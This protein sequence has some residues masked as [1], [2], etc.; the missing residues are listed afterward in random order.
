MKRLILTI[1][2][3]L[4]FILSG[5]LI[6]EYSEKFYVENLIA[7]KNIW[8]YL[9][10]YKVF[11][12]YFFELYDTDKKIDKF[13]VIFKSIQSSICSMVIVVFTTFYL[14]NFA[15]PRSFIIITAFIDIMYL[16]I[17]RMLLNSINKH[18]NIC[19][20]CNDKKTFE[21]IKN[22]LLF[23]NEEISVEHVNKD[24]SKVK[25]IIKNCNCD[26]LIFSSE[27]FKDFDFIIRLSWYAYKN[28]VNMSLFPD[29]S[30]SFIS[31]VDMSDIN[32]VPLINLGK[33]RLNIWQNTVK[34]TVDILISLVVFIFLIP[35]L[36]F[37]A[38]IIKYDSKGP[39]F[40]SQ[41]RI[42]YKGEKFK[43]IKFRT[44]ID[45]AEKN[46]GPKFADKDDSR[47]TS[48]GRFL[49]KYRIDELPQFFNVFMGNMSVVGP[50]PEREI[51]IKKYFYKLP[52]Y[53]RRTLVKPGITGLAQIHGGYFTKPEE[54]MKFDLIYINNYSSFLDIKLI[55]LTVYYMFK[56][57]GN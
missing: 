38:F 31:K 25:E 12:N 42:G 2:D 29:I 7:F 44:M 3:I 28:N 56:G 18:K 23:Y 36:P 33:D 43:V 30:Y 37:I 22:E 26:K 48:I 10:F 52:G 32:G 11:F 45:E 17:T 4:F 35:L 24:Y 46:T 15:L 13:F 9:I 1:T 8:I 21:F 47:I 16:S 57:R 40:Y 14:R 5:F 34:R 27:V 41:E 51:F 54:K 20:V 6:L 39:L 55:V 19:I 49:R 53:F 50:R